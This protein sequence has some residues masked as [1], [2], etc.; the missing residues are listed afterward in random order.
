MKLTNESILKN[1]IP[2][3]RVSV[4]KEL[5]TKQNLNQHEIAELLGITQA[6]VS[7]YLS[8][9]YSS[10]IK[11]LEQTGRVRNIS[12]KIT[13][14]IVLTKKMEPTEIACDDCKSYSGTCLYKHFIFE[15]A[16][17]LREET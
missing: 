6:A 4:A 16:K 17:A 3:I 11:T 15:L 2:S 12:K 14:K 7:K 9:N 5:A 13:G 1:F 10:V 8:G